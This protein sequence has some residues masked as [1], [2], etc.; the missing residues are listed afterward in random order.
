MSNE[1]I[2]KAS[3]SLWKDQS[4]KNW[5]AF[6]G[7]IKKGNA[8]YYKVFF[9]KEAKLKKTEDLRKS[10]AEIY[11][12][13]YRPITRVPIFKGRG[14]NIEGATIYLKGLQVNHRVQI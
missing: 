4:E 9:E 11:D 7:A 8:R 3:E 6:S 12:S 5:N 1:N 14:K 13:K 10:F 2:R